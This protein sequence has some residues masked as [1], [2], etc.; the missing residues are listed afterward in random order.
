MNLI[1]G[2][3]QNA[4]KTRDGGNIEIR[5]PR[6]DKG[7]YIAF[8]VTQK[9]LYAISII[10]VFEIHNVLFTIIFGRAACQY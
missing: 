8:I 3:R 5:S 9:R 2:S 6:K 4:E 1:L 7:T 10:I